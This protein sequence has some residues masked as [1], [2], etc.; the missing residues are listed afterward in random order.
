MSTLRQSV[1]EL[2]ATL[3][4]A[5]PITGGSVS[6]ILM[7]LTDS[8]MVGHV[9][10]V[11]LAASAFAGS[12]FG[13]FFIVGIGLLASISVLVARAHGAD[14]REECSQ[15]LR[16]GLIVALAVGLLEAL[17]IAGLATQLSR[18]GQPVEVV[19]AVNPF[20][21]IIGVSLVPTFVFQ[22]LRQFSEALGRPWQPM[23]ILLLSVGLNAFLNWVLIFGHLGAPALGLT[24][25]GCATLLAR[26]LSVV[27]LWVWL[28]RQ[29]GVGVLLPRLRDFAGLS[30]A[31]FREIFGI[32]LPVA[33]QLL[34]EGGAFSAAALMI[35]WLGTVP[36]AAHQI[37]LSCAAFTFMFPLGI[38]MAVSIR[39]SQAVGAGRREMLRPIG[40]GA[41]G[42]GIV[43]MAAFA[44]VFAVAGGWIA[45]GFTPEPDV[46]ALATRLLLVAAVFQI[47]D[48]GQVVG[49][50]ALR[51]LTD[52]KIPTVITFIAYWLV[53]LPSGYLLGF[54]M[55]LGAAGVWAGLAAGLA[56]AAVLLAVRL[57]RATAHRTLAAAGD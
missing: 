23:I 26:F 4:L 21:V 39:L 19:K 56:C 22:V 30:W 40:F 38:S 24:G 14:R 6:Q 16:H 1:S 49:S 52:V 32:G 7:G 48:G 9:G 29:P 53:A 28:E 18:F 17:L 45:R 20:F 51:G 2:R 41:L 44:L 13:L 27:F 43:I 34:F 36:L 31:H 55:E 42:L 8:A 37:A 47:F 5:L 35:G 57:A 11:P 12:V 15:W 54:K 25:S 3:A 50:G 46:I 33:G 10:K